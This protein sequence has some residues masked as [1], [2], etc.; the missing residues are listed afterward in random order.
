MFTS[1]IIAC[2]SSPRKICD[3]FQKRCIREIIY[4]YSRSSINV[5][6]C[7]SLWN[8]SVPWMRYIFSTYHEWTV[9]YW[10][11][12]LILWTIKRTRFAKA[13]S[14]ISMSIW[15]NIRISC[16]IAN[17]AYGDNECYAVSLQYLRIEIV[18]D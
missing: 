14:K 6:Q 11:F 17:V 9:I 13:T 18:N 7:I 15:G 16:N 2:F 10:N 12:M 5:P 1:V 3:M 8:W 4:C